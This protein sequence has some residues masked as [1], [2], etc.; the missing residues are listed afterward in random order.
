MII[1][2]QDEVSAAPGWMDAYLLPIGGALVVLLV[3]WFASGWVRAAI[4]KGT[5]KAKVDITLGKFLG[6]AARWVILVIAFVSV[7]GMVGVETT[8]FAAVLAAVGFAVGFALKDTLS[9]LAAGVLLLIFR[10]FKVGDAVTIS[11]Q[12]GTVDEIELFFTTI[13]TFDG[14]RLVIPNSR[15]SGA[16]IENISHHPRRRVEVKVGTEYDA[17]VD[18]TRRVLENSYSDIEGVLEEPGPGVVLMELG[19]SAVLW[20]VRVWA[21]QGDVGAVKQGLTRA[22]KRGL[23]AAGIGIPYPQMGVFLKREEGSHEG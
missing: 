15:V 7:L 9:D 13:D 22:V 17:D 5:E 19:D 21:M 11:G 14:K 2:A 3:A 18:E 8:S 16:T 12:T 20:S 1:L 6:N 4:R 10:P 23:D